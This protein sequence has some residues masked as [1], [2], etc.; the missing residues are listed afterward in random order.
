MSSLGDAINHWREKQDMSLNQLATDAGI[1]KSH[2]WELERGSSA[3]PRI[4]TLVRIA[5]ALD[6]DPRDFF[7][8]AYEDWVNNNETVQVIRTYPPKKTKK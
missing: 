7:L 4:D 1:T 8:C 2:I 3:N 5:V 6:A